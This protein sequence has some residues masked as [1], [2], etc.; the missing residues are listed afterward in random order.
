MRIAKVSSKVSSKMQTNLSWAQV[1]HIRI[2]FAGV[3]APAL[4]GVALSGSFP[5]ALAA[6]PV[7]AIAHASKATLRAESLAIKSEIQFATVPLTTEKVWSIEP[8]EPNPH[9]S[10]WAV[11]REVSLPDLKAVAVRGDKFGVESGDL[12]V[13]A[14]VYVRGPGPWYRSWNEYDCAR[15]PNAWFSTSDGNHLAAEEAAQSW[16]SLLNQRKRILAQ[17]LARLQ[18]RNDKVA[19]N[20]ARQALESWLFDVESEWLKTGKKNARAREWASYREQ[21]ATEGWCAK[22]GKGGNTAIYSPAMA[23]SPHSGSV[24][25]PPAVSHRVAV[26][27]PSTP[28]PSWRDL[29]EPP[30]PRPDLPP[31]EQLI[32]RLPAHRWDGLYSVHLSLIFANRALTGQFLLDSSAPQSLVSP[33]WLENQG[34]QPSLVQLQGY[35]TVPVQWSGGHGLGH[36]AVPFS[37]VANDVALSLHDFLLL[38]TT[39]RFVGPAFRHP[40]CDGV[41]GADFFRTYSIKFDPGPPY[42]VELWKREGFAPPVNGRDGKPETWDWI[43]AATL[44]QGGTVSNG[45]TLGPVPG[46]RWDT[47]LVETAKLHGPWAARRPSANRLS[48]GA[49]P[50]GPAITPSSRGSQPPFETRVPGVSIGMGFLGNAPLVFDLSHGRIWFSSAIAR[51]PLRNRT[52]LRVGYSVGRLGRELRVIAIVPGSPASHLAGLQKGS[53]IEEIDA[54]QPATL[55]AWLVDQRLAGAYG[56]EVHLKWKNSGRSPKAPVVEYDG[57]LKTESGGPAMAVTRVGR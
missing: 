26:S 54:T 51:P 36:P 8:R 21:A 37:A 15:E 30:A 53:L 44:T 33:T 3:C 17:E 57:V 34:V 1:A 47:G 29:M 56:T 49:G 55:D 32:A 6:S 11:Q 24:S 39:E 31:M 16:I 38:E 13:K 9:R 22:I 27:H 52:G 7:L 2:G 10:H 40:C 14:V 50:V 12:A 19:E 23:G 48:C 45:C 25:H 5:V 43:E 20:L 41:L 28:A 35:P 18:G 46:V 42:G 4:I